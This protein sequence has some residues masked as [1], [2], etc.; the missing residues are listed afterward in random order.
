MVTS[1]KL[2]CIFDKI[3]EDNDDS[4]EHTLHE[5]NFYYHTLTRT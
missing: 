2:D 5:G 1:M 4:T 3:V